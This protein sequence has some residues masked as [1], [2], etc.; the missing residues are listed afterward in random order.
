M[1]REYTVLSTDPKPVN[2]VDMGSILVE[3]DTGN[4]FFFNESAGEWV[5][6]FSLM[7]GGGGGGNPNTVQTITGT[8]AEPFGDFDKGEELHTAIGNGN[9]SA[10]IVLDIS[11]L[12]MGLNTLWGW[13]YQ[14][15]DNEHYYSFYTSEASFGTEGLT[16]GFFASIFFPLDSGEY[17]P[18]LLGQVG[19]DYLDLTEYASIIPTTLTI[20]WHPLPDQS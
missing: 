19:A 5:E 6:Q 4:V 2:G 11:A 9:A 14:G 20:I 13:L 18:Q 1:Q 7:D 12:Q 17:T 3:V 8:L 16:F 10:K 15:A